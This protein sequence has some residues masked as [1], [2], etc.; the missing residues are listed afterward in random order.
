MAPQRSVAVVP[1][2]TTRSSG[3]VTMD[4]RSENTSQSSDTYRR[5]CLLPP[6]Q[7]TGHLTSKPS[8]LSSR[9]A[10]AQ[11]RETP[12][13]AAGARPLPPPPQATPRVQVPEEV[14]GEGGC[15]VYQVIRSH[16]QESIRFPKITGTPD[17][18]RPRSTPDLQS[19]SFITLLLSPHSSLRRCGITPSSQDSGAQKCRLLVPRSWS[20]LRPRAG[21][22]SA[23]TRRRHSGSPGDSHGVHS[24]NLGVTHG[25]QGSSGCAGGI[26]EHAFPGGGG[27]GDGAAG[28]AAAQTPGH[29]GRV[30]AATA[31]P[32]STAVLTLDLSRATQLPGQ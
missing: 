31:A 12:S 27:R 13:H 20:G 4:V 5:E 26:S 25:V 8:F 17:F 22:D 7:C 14:G 29:V 10:A 19:A 11:G 23:Q 30:P 9:P 32:A 15:D 1:L 24:P 18:C 6:G 28:A 16:C 21:L 3:G 2:I